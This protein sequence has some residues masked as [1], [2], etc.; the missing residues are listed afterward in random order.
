MQ[1][2]TSHIQNVVRR[3]QKDY[4]ILQHPLF[5]VAC[6]SIRHSGFMLPTLYTGLEG[7]RKS[8]R[9]FTHLQSTERWIH[10]EAN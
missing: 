8:E 9:I 3:V 7:L 4:L 6:T 2:R 5:V 10:K 1:V